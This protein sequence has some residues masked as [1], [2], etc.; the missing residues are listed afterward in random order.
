MKLNL[1]NIS[2]T[3]PPTG[4]GMWVGEGLLGE[5]LLGWVMGAVDNKVVAQM[6]VELVV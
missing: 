2:T 5:R 3:P 6:G 4:T 1:L